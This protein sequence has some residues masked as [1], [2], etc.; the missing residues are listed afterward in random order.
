M[1]NLYDFIVPKNET[2]FKNL[3]MD[4]THIN[5]ILFGTEAGVL[6]KLEVVYGELPAGQSMKPG[7]VAKLF[8]IE[9]EWKKYNTPYLFQ[10]RLRH[11]DYRKLFEDMDYEIIEEKQGSIGIPPENISNKFDIQN[12][13][14]YILWAHFVLKV[15]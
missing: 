12:K 4:N 3:V 14:T 7:A 8:G 10:N 6:D 13:E 2:K 1:D 11:Q 15:K 9:K 5:D